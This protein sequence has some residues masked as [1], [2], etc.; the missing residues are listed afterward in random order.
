VDAALWQ[1]ID[2]VPF[3]FN[4]RCVSVLLEKA[5]KRLLIIKGAPEDILKQR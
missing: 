4:R 3:D 1:K 2:E 5:D